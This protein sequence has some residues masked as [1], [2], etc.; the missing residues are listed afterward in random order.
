MLTVFGGTEQGNL[1][2]RKDG[3]P[4]TIAFLKQALAVANTE[5]VR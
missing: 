1:A 2:A 3:W 4:R 5:R